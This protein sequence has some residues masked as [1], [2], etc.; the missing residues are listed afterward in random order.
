M[1]QRSAP[2]FFHWIHRLNLHVYDGLATIR[3]MS[4]GIIPITLFAALLFTPTNALG[5]EPAPVADAQ[6]MC[7]LPAIN[8]LP[9]RAALQDALT[10]LDGSPIRTRD[11]WE[12]KRRPQLKSLFENYVYGQAPPPPGITARITKE[13]VVLDGK[14]KLKEI[15]IKLNGLLDDAP[16]IRLALFVPANAKGKVP[17]FLTVNGGGNQAV[18]PDEAV[19]H[20]VKAWSDQPH[21]RGSESDFWCV[22]DVIKRGYAFATFHQSDMAPDTPDAGRQSIIAWYPNLA[23]PQTRWGTLAAWAWGLSRAVDYLE[24][25][26]DIDAKQ[27]AVLGHSRRGKAALLAGAFDERIWLTVPHQ[28]GTG[29]CA[30]SRNNDQE[31]VEKIN[32]SF[33][34]WFNDVFP[35]FAGREDR[36]PV[37]QHLLVAMIAPRLLL[38]TEGTQDKWA[39]FESALT[40]LRE[41]D[42]VYKFHD[43]KGMIGNGVISGDTTFTPENCGDLVQ[44]RLDET[45]TLN[46]RYWK[47][48]L[49]FADVQQQR[50][51]RK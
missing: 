9:V 10:M 44:Y 38:D 42:K 24:T 31:T 45:H 21:A 47:A 20:N 16:R 39:N 51:V 1:R 26:G 34:H 48:I 49:D 15:E 46:A 35:R 19:T 8:D 4:H 7:D 2:M 17:V 22:S 23:T 6:L 18:V 12:Q 33:P 14:A 50:E 36:L 40:A 28:S 41:A 25:D 43:A 37:D 30:L 32:R 5:T 29:G 3:A 27:M 11:D 13:A